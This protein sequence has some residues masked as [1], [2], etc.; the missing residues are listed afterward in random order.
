[1]ALLVLSNVK[2]AP[3]EVNLTPSSANSD[4]DPVP[5]PGYHH[6]DLPNGLRHAAAG[7]LAERGVAGFSLREVA[8]RAGVSHAAPAHHFGDAEG[9]LTSVAIEAFQHLAAET[10]AAVTGV[11]DPVEALARLGRAYVSVSVRHPG[12]CAIVFREDA[13]DADD[14]DYQAWG[15]R[16]F[17]VLRSTIQRLADERNPE[18]DVLQASFLCHAMVQGLVELHG[19]MVGLGAIH[20]VEVGAV[21]DLAEAFTRQLV[22]GFAP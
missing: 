1:V 19:T 21:E 17:E 20:Q 9:L 4:T 22:A 15:Q 8:R 11:D 13:I 12:H 16:A 5:P 3:Y 2:L 14:A 18:L 6:G 7:L 10:E